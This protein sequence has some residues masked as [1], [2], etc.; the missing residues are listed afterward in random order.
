MFNILVCDDD[1]EIVDAIDIYLS[2]EGYHIL[3]AYDGLQAIEIMKKEEVH[4]I[5]L[6]IMMPNLDGIRA[7]RKIRETSS[8][9]IIMLSA[10][11]EDVDKILGLNIGADDY[12][13]KPFNSLE[14]IA[15]VKSQ[16]RRYTQL[17]NLA[18]EE[19][20]AVYVCGGL[21]VNDDL[22]TVTVDGEPVKLT[23]IEYNILV[24]LIKNQGKVFS[25]EQIYE[26]IWNEEA[27]GADNTVAVHIRHIREKIEI[28]PREPRYLKVVWGIGYK[29]E[30]M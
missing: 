15:R 28:N 16:L 5:L 20:E 13:T 14:L 7:T 1:K 30:K 12:I 19:K 6:D 3:K 2:Q 26:N 24:L 18:T 27:I 21:V 29:I 4:L 22:K 9:P 11:S 17:G 23:P 10:K 8:V 25:I